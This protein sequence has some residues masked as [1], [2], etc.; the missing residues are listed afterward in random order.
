MK[1]LLTA[2]LMCTL[3]LS[4]CGFWMN[5]EYVSVEP[6]LDNQTAHN[7]KI[8]EAQNYIQL[9]DAL[10]DLVENSKTE[11]TVIIATLEQ[12][13]VETYMQMAEDHIKNTSAIGAYTVDEISYEVGTSLGKAAVAVNFTYNNNQS[14]LKKM[15]RAN[16]M[17]E[18]AQILE[19]A[20]NKC[21][22][23]VV[24]L[25]DGYDGTDFYQMIQDYTVQRPDK[26]MELP[27][28]Q[29]SIY[30]EKGKQRVVDI[31][32]TYQTNRETLRTM[33][34]TVDPVFT[35]A[36]LYVSGST[37]DQEKLSLLYAFLM[38]RYNYTVEASITPTY[39]LLCHGVGDSKAFAV[40]YAAMCR[41]AGLDCQMVSG[42]KDSE[43]WF[44][45]V[46]TLDGQNYH[47]DLLQCSR[48]DG[49]R[50]L[51]EHQMDGYVWDFSAYPA[52]AVQGE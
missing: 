27:Q 20:M 47:L 7:D 52:R 11:G 32:F 10:V 35:S 18:A 22:A 16:D 19:N 46:V 42:T 17:E 23:E 5:K 28:T 41:Q 12:E 38:E 39:S 30:P 48:A 44:W 3:L 40:V 31:S 43:P 14:S 37:K 50:L 45:N 8:P 9:R 1:R 15:Q 34:E 33:R 2:L 29:V 4:G 26:V 21:E 25:V 6:Y 24:F 49:F 36:R 51:A 13:N